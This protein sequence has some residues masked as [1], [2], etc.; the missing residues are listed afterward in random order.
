M[1][2]TPLERE[3]KELI[4]SEGPISM[5]HYMGLA[6]GHPQHGYYMGRDPFGARGDFITAPEVS[7]IFGELIGVWAAA[8]YQMLGAP[9]QFHLV[10][11]GPGRGTLM[12][13]ML[14]AAK[15]MPGFLDA[16]KVH[17]VEMSPALRQNQKVKLA[18]SGAAVQWHERFEDVPEGPLIVVANEFFDALP[19]HQFQK[20]QQGWC[21]RVIGL[22][23]GGELTIGLQQAPVREIPKWAETGEV[24]AI[25]E[26]APVRAQ[27]AEEL[28][29]RMSKHQGFGVFID[30]GH[31]RSGVGDTLQALSKH[32]YA[33]VLHQPGLCDIT[34]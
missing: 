30:Y 14:R 8:A 31:S 5:A 23:E 7:Q 11:L 18:K 10:E 4:A 6:L 2:E 16:A 29:K 20:T 19:V 3:L 9:E 22:D 34:S 15:V 28:G 26:L 33:D 1:S 13:D 12:S 17:L 24:G 25:C 32:K 27:I 21:E